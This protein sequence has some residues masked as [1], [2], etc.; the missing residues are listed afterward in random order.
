MFINPD[1]LDEY[2]QKY[3][4]LH[5]KLINELIDDGINFIKKQLQYYQ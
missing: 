2:R 4:S 3:D 5:M 1:L